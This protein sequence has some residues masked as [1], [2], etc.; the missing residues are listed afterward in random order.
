[1]AVKNNITRFV[2]YI[3][4]II[5]INCF[6]SFEIIASNSF[7][8]IR[9]KEIL[10]D[11]IQLNSKFIEKFEGLYVI[12]IGVHDRVKQSG[13]IGKLIV[14]NIGITFESEIYSVSLIRS[15]FESIEKASE[16]NPNTICFNCRIVNRNGET[17]SSKS[18]E[19]VTF[20][21]SKSKIGNK[22]YLYG[23]MTTLIGKKITT[24]TFRTK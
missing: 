2:G 3:I 18:G 15:L 11:T 10:S 21:L 1:M 22:E 16:E 7:E 23:G 12:D 9:K 4:T 24:T 13:E 17:I 8:F 20:C 14:T 5:A 6:P 19:T